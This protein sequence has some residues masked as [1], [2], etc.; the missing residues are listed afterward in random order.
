MNHYRIRVIGKVQGVFYRA[1]TRKKAHELGING[2]VKNETDGSVLIA[3]E[4][5]ENQL[6]A[7]IEWCKQGPAH[8]RVIEVRFEQIKPQGFKE[9]RIEY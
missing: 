5:E 6:K 3:A 9:F 2:W 1:S 7:L 4:G 8:A